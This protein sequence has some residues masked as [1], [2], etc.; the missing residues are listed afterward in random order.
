MY[1]SS[2]IAAPLYKNQKNTKTLKIIKF[3]KTK[4]KNGPYWVH[5]LSPISGFPRLFLDSP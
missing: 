5:F 2:D 4:K 3:Q 1:I